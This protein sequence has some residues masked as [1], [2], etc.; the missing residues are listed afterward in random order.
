MRTLI[1]LLSVTYAFDESRLLEKLNG[2]KTAKELY[3]FLEEVQTKIKLPMELAVTEPSKFEVLYWQ[4]V[5]ESNKGPPSRRHLQLK[6]LFNQLRDYATAYS[7]HLSRI[8]EQK[9]H[10]SFQPYGTDSKDNELINLN[11]VQ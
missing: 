4:R 3:A 10:P 1:L 6:D 8:T 2:V 7:R 9:T 11:I 5:F